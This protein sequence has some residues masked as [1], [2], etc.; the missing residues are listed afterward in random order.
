MRNKRR[1]IG[2]EA[3]KKYQVDRKRSKAKKYRESEK[4]KINSF[5]VAETRRNNKL[6]LIEYK[7]GK[8]ERCGYNKPIPGAYEFH[9]KDPS[10]KDFGISSKGE[11]RSLEKLKNEVDKCMLLC[12]NCHAEIHHEINEENRNKKYNQFLIQ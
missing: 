9:H 10:E 12:S 7:G 6:K 5:K 1:E 2:E 3:W 8:C 4:G 11:T